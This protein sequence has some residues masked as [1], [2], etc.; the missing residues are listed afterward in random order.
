MRMRRKYFDAG[1]GG[2]A[3]DGGQGDGGQGG[4]DGGGEEAK[5]YDS[6]PEELRNNESI[7]GFADEAAFAKS[8]VDTKAALTRTQQD[9][10]QRPAGTAIVVP[11]EDATEQQWA[12]YR[13]AV[14]I[15]ETKEAYNFPDDRPGDPAHPER[16]P[17]R[18]DD[19]LRA[20]LTERAF[21]QNM[22]QEQFDVA[23]GLL[24]DTIE[25]A[26]VLNADAVKADHDRSQRLLQE[27]FGSDLPKLQADLG[28]LADSFGQP[29]GDQNWYQDLQR[30]KVFPNG[31]GNDGDFQTFEMRILS[32]MRLE[33]VGPQTSGNSSSRTREGT[34]RRQPASRRALEY[35]DM[36]A[37]GMAVQP[38]AGAFAAR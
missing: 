37:N 19:S 8:F 6:L 23:T 25:K 9:L 2:G 10:A 21:A 28:R 15:P 30:R 13:K 4:G 27:R 1:D 18:I 29:I 32:A 34:Q 11:G 7:R 14:G 33:R 16:G 35:P 38:T 20:E 3:G 31:L 12:D 22:T 24:V 17:V 5:W 26:T 36:D